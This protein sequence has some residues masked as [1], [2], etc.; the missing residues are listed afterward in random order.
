MGKWGDG[1]EENWLVHPL[2]LTADKLLTVMVLVRYVVTAG[3]QHIAIPG[4]APGVG[5]V[6]GYQL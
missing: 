6:G 2:W 1:I 5:I 3:I 4:I